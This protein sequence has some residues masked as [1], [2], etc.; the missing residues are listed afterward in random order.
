M[1]HGERS[2]AEVPLCRFI[3]PKAACPQSEFCNREI[4]CSSSGASLPSMRLG[5]ERH[6]DLDRS[7][8][9]HSGSRVA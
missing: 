4:A 2:P 3:D 9:L 1:Y 5:E 6:A 8:V 7:R